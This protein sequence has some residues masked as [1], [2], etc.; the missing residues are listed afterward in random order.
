MQ[1]M[2]TVL[3]ISGE[4]P[5][6]TN[7]NCIISMQNKMNFITIK[8]MSIDDACAES[9]AKQAKKNDEEHGYIQHQDIQPNKKVICKRCVCV[10]LDGQN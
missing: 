6:K 9:T 4:K 10:V 8:A 5:R 7:K 3:T 2:K 1:K